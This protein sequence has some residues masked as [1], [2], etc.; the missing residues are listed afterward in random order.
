MTDW[1]G[2]KTEPRASSIAE[3]CRASG[4]DYKWLITGAGEMLSPPAPQSQQ[5]S[6]PVTA[7]ETDDDLTLPPFSDFMRTP[8]KRPFRARF[9]WDS[10]DENASAPPKT[11]IYKDDLATVSY[12]ALSGGEFSPPAPREAADSRVVMIPLYEGVQPSAGHGSAVRSEAPTTR[13]AFDLQWLK[14]IGIQPDAAVVLPARGDSMSPT[15]ENGAPM[16]VDTSKTEITSGYIYV[17]AVEDDLLVKRVRRRLDGSIELISDNAI[18]GAET[19]DATRLGQ[20]R[21]VGR[22]FATVTRF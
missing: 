16:L 7:M 21:V 12:T 5:Q 17:I 2:D 11:A 18:Y 9:G 8:Q 10:P 19:L 4:V 6:L 15:I 3:I 14:F 13:M 20:L 22:V 1:V